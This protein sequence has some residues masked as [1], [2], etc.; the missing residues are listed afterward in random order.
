MQLDIL[1]GDIF[2]ADL[3]PGVGCEQG[4]TRPVLVIQNNT[5]DNYSNTTIVAAITAKVKPS[6]PT[7]VRIPRTMG[8]RDNSMVLLEQIRTI[9]KSRLGNKLGTLCDEQLRFIDRALIASLGVRGIP[10]DFMIMSPCRHCA[11][12]FHNSGN[13]IL[14]PAD[15]RQEVR[16]P[17]TFCST[18]TGYDYEVI[19]L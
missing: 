10:H 2:I 7:H 18:R 6:L 3:N 1:R 16:E 14:R 12:T 5:G 8:I 11:Q 15:F 4:G 19:R 9:D 17:C 13:Y